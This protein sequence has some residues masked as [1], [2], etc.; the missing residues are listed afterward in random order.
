MVRYS[1]LHLAVAW[2]GLSAMALWKIGSEL[3]ALVG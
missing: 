2:I 3:Y 1:P